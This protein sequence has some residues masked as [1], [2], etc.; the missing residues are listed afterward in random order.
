MCIY[1]IYTSL[2]TINDVIFVHILDNFWTVLE[3]KIHKPSLFT[4]QHC[5]GSAHAVGKKGRSRQATF[6]RF[7]SVA[8][9]GL[10]RN[11]MQKHETVVIKLFV[12]W[13]FSF[14]KK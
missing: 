14:L 1:I 3:K 11:N 6:F 13:F 9:V 4:L 12:C 5:C 10:L 2:C 8:T 7:C